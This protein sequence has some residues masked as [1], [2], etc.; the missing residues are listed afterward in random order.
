[1]IGKQR[2]ISMLNGMKERETLMV[3]FGPK[4]VPSSLKRIAGK[5]K[6]TSKKINKKTP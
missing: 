3:L 1:M 6:K 4:K 2:T 5:K